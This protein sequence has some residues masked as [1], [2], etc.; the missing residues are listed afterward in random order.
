MKV[1]AMADDFEA[2]TWDDMDEFASRRS[3]P[4]P[5][6][7]T[8]R[9][10]G[11]ATWLDDPRI[12]RNLHDKPIPVLANAVIGLQADPE[13]R[14]KICFDEMLRAPTW[15][16]E[17]PLTDAD[18]T[19]VQ[20]YLQHAGL[21]NVSHET[22]HRAIDLYARDNAYH[23]IR[24][25]LNALEWDREQR[26]E[27]WLTTY[28]GA[29]AS[30]Y[31]Q[32][33]GRMFLISMVA[34]IYKPG[35]KVDYMP[36]L[37]GPQSTLKS[38]ACAVLGGKWFSDSLPEIT[39]GKDVSMHLRGKWLI[40]VSEMHAMNRAETSLLKSFIT[41]DTERFRPPYGRL[42]VIEP[43]QCVFAG[44]TNRE[45]YLRDETGGR[46]FWP[47]KCVEINKDA[48]ERD[49]DQ[50]FAETVVLY[51]A[52]VPWW[53]HRDFERDHMMPQQEQRYEADAWEEAISNFLADKTRVTVW[54]VAKDGLCIETPRIS[55]TD[56]NRIMAALDRLRWR[57]ELDVGKT[58]W[59]GK[60]WWIRV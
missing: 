44:T 18:V 23:P 12:I 47:F 7:R 41:R 8:E 59:Q 55:R 17:R 42:E 22:V 14:G 25:Y 49:R 60:R 38:T 36:I 6:K 43:R 40:E 46:R 2:P 54:Q 33:I 26:V 31:V 50:L 4:R 1:T 28:F 57:R 27:R 24:D 20:D 35:C 19:R 48:L 13:L 5:R 15:L 45:T 39:S 52:K 29:E 34:R 51:R 10:N 3:R 53:P 11:P 30:P 56:Q 58:D 32:G 9:G 21:Q 16:K 37:E